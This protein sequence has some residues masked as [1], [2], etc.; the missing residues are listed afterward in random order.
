VLSNRTALAPAPPTPPPSLLDAVDALV[1]ALVGAR[2]AAHAAGVELPRGAAA[3]LGT[4]ARFHRAR[5]ACPV[6]AA[7]LS[8]SPGRPGFCPQ[9]D[10]GR[11]RAAREGR[12]R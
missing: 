10:G 9:H 7:V 12:R 6:C 5:L 3:E 2:L 1:A 4:W 11:R 8:G